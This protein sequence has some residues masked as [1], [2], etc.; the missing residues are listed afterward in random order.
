M[1]T[2]YETIINE[3]K[4]RIDQ[5][6][7]QLDLPLP[8][9]NDLAKEFNV[10]RMTV[11]KALDTLIN[12]GLLY[13]KRG[14]GTFIRKSSAN[15]RISLPV[16]EHSGL[17]KSLAQRIESQII[18]FNVTFPNQEVCE[19]LEIQSTD[20]VYDILRLRL[21]NH[22]PFVLEHTYMPTN[23]IQGLSQEILKKSIYN[24][25]EN[26]LKLTIGDA[27]RQITAEKA[28]L[29]DCEYLKVEPTDPI[30]QVNQIVYLK[31]GQ[32]FETS[33]SRHPYNKHIYTIFDRKK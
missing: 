27:F 19:K 33:T 5:K 24:Y 2:K 18:S 12:E 20:P 13:S 3:L 28:T 21:V 14:A 8:N 4:K 10:S 23:L 6:F 15:Q 16:N 11:K 31:N 1:S 22:E 25:I 32:P 30:L 17:S 9:Q 7:Y 26:D 29:I